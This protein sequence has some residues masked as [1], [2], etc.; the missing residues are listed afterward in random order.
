MKKNEKV[1]LDLGKQPVSNKYLKSLKTKNNFYNFKIVQESKTGLIKIQKPFPVN[2]LRPT[3]DWITYDEPEDHLKAMVKNIIKL[4][5][6]KKNLNVGGISFKDD[7]TLDLFKKKG[8]YVWRLNVSKD[9]KLREGLGVES[10]QNKLSTINLTKIIKRY[11]EPD[12]LIVRHIWEH[13]YNQKKFTENL[14]KLLNKDSLVIFEIPDCTKLLKNNDYTMPWEEHLFYYT[15]RTFFKSLNNQGFSIVFSKIVKYPYEDIIYAIVKTSK[16]IINK[17]LI[18]TN[19]IKNEIK[20]AK[21][22]S[23]NFLIQKKNIHKFLKENK[24]KG[25]IAIFGAGHMAIS[26][27]SFFEIS[28]YID[29]VLDNNINKKGLFLPIGNKKIKDASILRNTKL[30]ICL[31]AMNPINHNKIIKKY[32]FFEKNGGKFISIYSKDIIN[33]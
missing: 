8:N 1:I 19:D 9:L 14:K 7:S 32:K 31:L 24:I 16:K 11:K 22:Y 18:K 2:S 30:K 4:L 25:K 5:K 21:N 13:I 29:Y 27:L 33:G 26:F 28:K 23:N 3:F 20:L 17:N 6:T 15:P 12:V 10:I